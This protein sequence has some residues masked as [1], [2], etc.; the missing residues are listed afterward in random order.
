MSL[1]LSIGNRQEILLHHGHVLGLTR[2]ARDAADAIGLPG[3]ACSG[4]CG[5]CGGTGTARP[6]WPTG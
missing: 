3:A 6:L 4:R 5:H 1:E 2:L